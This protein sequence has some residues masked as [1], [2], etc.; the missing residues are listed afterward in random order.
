MFE[1]DPIMRQFLILRTQSVAQLENV[2]A[3]DEWDESTDRKS[4]LQNPLI[5]SR[6]LGESGK[7]R[8]VKTR[9]NTAD[10]T[11]DADDITSTE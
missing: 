10:F 7:E 8:S 1:K 2:A 3:F 6:K 5:N 11:G 9:P 4:S